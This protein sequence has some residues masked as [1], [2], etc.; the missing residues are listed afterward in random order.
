MLDVTP[1]L[2]ERRKESEVNRGGFVPPKA[3]GVPPIYQMQEDDQRRDEQ[4]GDPFELPNYGLARSSCFPRSF[5]S[6]PS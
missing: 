4:R 1:N 2:S 3:P 5:H 6:S